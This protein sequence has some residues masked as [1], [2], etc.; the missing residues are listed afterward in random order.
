MI[1]TSSLKCIFF[2]CNKC[3]KDIRY[4]KVYFCDDLCYCDNCTPWNEKRLMSYSFSSL[5]IQDFIKSI[6]LQI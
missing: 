1:N 3:N 5:N 2:I 4:T 6:N